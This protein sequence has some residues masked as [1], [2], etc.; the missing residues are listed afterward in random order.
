MEAQTIIMQ[1]VVKAD[2]TVEVPGKVG[3]AP[4]PVEVTLPP[5]TSGG[6]TFRLKGKG[7][8][9]KS[10]RGDLL[11]TVRIALP[12]RSDAELETLM[13]KWAAG[14]PYNPRKDM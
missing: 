13:K 7:F 6:R 5:W 9:A 12:E 8:P 11:A 10:G 3:L 1:G 2:G 14:K 4:G